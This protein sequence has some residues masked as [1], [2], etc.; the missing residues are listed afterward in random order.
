MGAKGR[1][2]KKLK[3]ILTRP[4]PNYYLKNVDEIRRKT[5]WRRI[6][7]EAGRRRTVVAAN[8]G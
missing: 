8:S 6:R 4:V 1:P 5:A 2:Q 3:K 7:Q